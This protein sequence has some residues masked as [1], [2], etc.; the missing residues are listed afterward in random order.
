MTP[1]RRWALD[2][3]GTQ[4]RRMSTFDPMAAAVDWL[5]VYR[6]ASSQS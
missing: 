6:A 1:A 5:D 3:A 4:V 2:D